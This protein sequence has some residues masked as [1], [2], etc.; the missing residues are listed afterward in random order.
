MKKLVNL[1]ILLLLAFIIS[2]IGCTAD[3][4]GFVNVANQPSVMVVDSDGDIIT[5]D[6]ATGAIATIVNEHHEIHE[7]DFFTILDVAD[8]GNGAVRN[9]LIVTPDTTAWAHLV[10]EIEHELETLI[11]FY[12]NTLYSDN[13]TIITSFNRNGNSSNVATTL[14]FHTPTITDN[15]TLMGNIQQGDGKKAGGADRKANEFILRQNC[16]YLIKITNLTVNNNLIFMKLNWYEHV[17]LE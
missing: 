4:P 2:F 11:Q 15:G 8:L 10:W 12:Q 17:N 1:S 14:V 6:S 13:G 7:G 16:A 3:D 9:I 5:I